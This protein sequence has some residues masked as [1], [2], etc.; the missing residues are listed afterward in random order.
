MKAQ[1]H[2]IDHTCGRLGTMC[3]FVGHKKADSMVVLAAHKGGSSFALVR[4]C[5]LESLWTLS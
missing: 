3:G 4:P 5:S 2:F 1:L